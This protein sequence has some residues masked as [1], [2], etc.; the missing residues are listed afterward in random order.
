[1]EKTLE[2]IQRDARNR[3]CSKLDTMQVKNEFDLIQY[4]LYAGRLYSLGIKEYMPKAD[5]LLC[6]SSYNNKINQIFLNRIDQGIWDLQ[7]QEGKEIG[8]SLTELQDMHSFLKHTSYPFSRRV[9][10]SF[11][12]WI[13]AGLYA[14]VNAETIDYIN[15]FFD[16]NPLASSDVLEALSQPTTQEVRELEYLLSGCRYAECQ[17]HAVDG[18]WEFSDA[19]YNLRLEF[20][21]S[22]ENALCFEVYEP[23]MDEKV[24]VEGVT[25]RQ[26]IIPAVPDPGSPLNWS[27]DYKRFPG[28]D[29]SE[30]KQAPLTI[31][32]PMGGICKIPVPGSAPISTEKINVG[33]K[34]YTV[35]R[36]IVFT[37]LAMSAAN[38]DNPDPI[39]MSVTGLD[40]YLKIWID[41]PVNQVIV[42]ACSSLNNSMTDRLDGWSLFGANGI[43]LGTFNGKAVKYPFSEDYIPVFLE[44]KNETQ[45]PLILKSENQP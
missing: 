30:R 3:Y 7:E 37:A 38:V 26:D 10:Q 15:D 5:D 8:I 32:L 9:R 23:R 13:E 1:M 27:V 29:V 45:Y 12:Q 17:P 44:D 19:G 22:A 25:I 33:K 24:P 18:A 11:T 40:V 4:C 41:K 34:P 21:P 6:N 16:A 2:E 42:Q 36:P 39:Q 20:K 35:Q 31:R 28:L 14:D 43:L